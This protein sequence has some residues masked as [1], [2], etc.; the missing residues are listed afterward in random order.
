MAWDSCNLR[1]EE[2]YRAWRDLCCALS[3]LREKRAA[4]PFPGGAASSNRPIIFL[5]PQRQPVAHHSGLPCGRRHSCGAGLTRGCERLGELLLD[6]GVQ[7][8]GQV[9][10]RPVEA[11]KYW[12]PT[13]ASELCQRFRRSAYPPP[14]LEVFA[15]LKTAEVAILVKRR[16]SVPSTGEFEWWRIALEIKSV[17][18]TLL[19]TKFRKIFLQTVCGFER[20]SRSF[21]CFIVYGVTQDN[22]AN[23]TK[24]CSGITG[25][26]NS[27]VQRPLVTM[28]PS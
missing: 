2:I 6:P 18:P 21:R 20:F 27:K 4:P 17:Y 12:S 26:Q 28:R 7:I 13:E 25:I 10:H 5:P 16:H 11:V 24:L 22:L 15:R 8:T 14:I 9:E 23:L 3:S 19:V 1:Q